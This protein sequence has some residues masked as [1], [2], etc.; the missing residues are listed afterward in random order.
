MQV[1]SANL[2][3]FTWLSIIPQKKRQNS[4]FT[5][6][7]Q[8]D[9]ELK[10]TTRLLN[11]MELRIKT[12]IFVIV[13]PQN[14]LFELSN[15]H[16]NLQAIWIITTTTTATTEKKTRTKT[17]N[18]CFYS[19]LGERCHD[20][21]ECGTVKKNVHRLSLLDRIH[22]CYKWTE[23]DPPIIKKKNQMEFKE[24]KK[25]KRRN[26]SMYRLMNSIEMSLNCRA[27]YLFFSLFISQCV[28]S[29][30]NPH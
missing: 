30:L 20:H 15:S 12:A 8:M 18:L 3:I 29:L 23:K 28:V 25:T 22:R 14:L 27:V 24:K 5:T 13:A 7:F 11:S 21:S 2:Y 26:A 6:E 4:K 1:I 10:K 17:A 16:F 19:P 9:K